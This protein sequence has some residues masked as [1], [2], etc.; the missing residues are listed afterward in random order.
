MSRTRL[1][2]WLSALVT[3]AVLFIVGLLVGG[4]FTLSERSRLE[5]R[6]TSLEAD[7]AEAGQL[8]AARD[9]VRSEAEGQLAALDAARREAESGLAARDKT[10]EDLQA[11]VHR[12][13]EVPAEVEGERTEARPESIAKPPAPV[14]TNPPAVSGGRCTATTLKGTRCK[15][16]ARS[17]GRCWQHGG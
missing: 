15:R 8:L 2:S 1:P 9:A 7:L 12:L 4:A 3:G 14:P 16:N 11:Q 17:Q 10:I 5:T 13:D 6:N